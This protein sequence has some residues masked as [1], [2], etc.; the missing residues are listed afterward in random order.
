MDCHET[1]PALGTGQGYSN[2]RTIIDTLLLSR[3]SIYMI[4][5]CSLFQSDVMRTRLLSIISIGITIGFLLGMGIVALLRATLDGASPE[6]E[7]AFT[8]MVVMM[9]GALVYYVVRTTR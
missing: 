9:G 5:E 8:L 4:G 1:P 3:V 2:C 7:V 6:L